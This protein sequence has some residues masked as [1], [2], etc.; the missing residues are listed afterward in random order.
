MKPRAAL[1]SK[2]E[3]RS[4]RTLYAWDLLIGVQDLTRQGVLRLRRPG[5]EAFLGDEKMA[6]PPVTTLR[7]L[8][9]VAYQFSNRRID[10]LDAL[11][12]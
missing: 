12:K 3:Q 9:A 6:A 4:S 5:T 11:R 2:D 10:D 8:E 1:Q 7:E